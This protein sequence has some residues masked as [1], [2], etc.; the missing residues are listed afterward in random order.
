MFPWHLMLWVYAFLC[1]ETPTCSPSS[2]FTFHLPPPGHQLSA[3]PFHCVRLLVIIITA[4]SHLHCQ[5]LVGFTISAQ[6]LHS[7]S[8]TPEITAVFSVCTTSPP[9]CS[10]FFLSCPSLSYSSCPFLVLLSLSCQVCVIS[11]VRVVSGKQGLLC[12]C[13]LMQED[14]KRGVHVSLWE[15]IC[16]P[17]SPGY[18]VSRWY[19]I[20]A[21][22]SNLCLLSEAEMWE[23]RQE[24]QVHF[25]PK[26]SQIQG[27]FCFCCLVCSP[28]VLKVWHRLQEMCFD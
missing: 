28:T 20:P 9:L 27:Y 6:T 10:T 7:N 13:A 2:S 1:S 11:E 5:A 18:Y 3:H 23:R 22:L 26:M 14:I 4:V 8:E 17:S 15:V 25:W 21:S 19:F 12:V 24:L 16:I